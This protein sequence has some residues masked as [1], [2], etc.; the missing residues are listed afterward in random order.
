MNDID[1]SLFRRLDLN[2]LVAFDA[3]VSEAS[4]TRAAARLCIGQPAM[5][6]ALARL[7]ELF[8]DDILY[9]E[10]SAMLPTSRARSLAP[11]V[12]ELLL[13]ARSLALGEA[14]FD[15]AQ[16]NEQF[17]IAL[18]DPLEALLLPA[19]MARLRARAP[20]LQL[21]VRPIPASHQLE[22]LD[23]GTIRLAVG[24]FPR[25]R[26]VHEQTALYETGFCCVFN[27]ALITLK[28]QPSLAD[29]TGLP[30][31]HTSYTGDGPGMIDRALHRRG[32]RRQ[33]V[34]HAATPL[35]IPF[36]VK[37]SPL[38]AVLPELVTRLLTTH[39]DLTILP[40]HEEDLRL[41]ISVVIHRRDTSD[42]LTGFMRETLLKIAHSVLTPAS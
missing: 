14:S 27:P 17:Q 18:N 12:R 9:R 15:P 20:G 40:L 7:R 34:A 38:V 11:A 19:L 5:S 39:R 23:A 22:E 16:I 36:V 29:L 42:P 6:H 2:L 3:L 21:S 31:I 25:V 32:L 24:H 28:D 10:G 35:S 41:P 26:T 1:H 4:V 13:S 37:Q 30:H 33:V 8:N